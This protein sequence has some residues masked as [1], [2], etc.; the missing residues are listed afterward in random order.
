MEAI[1]KIII[2]TIPVPDRLIWILDPKGKFSIKLVF[3]VSQDP[4]EQSQPNI[5]WKPFWK[6][7][8]HERLK[9]LVWRIANDIL[10]TNLNFCMRVGFG[11]PICP[12]CHSE[13]ESAL[14]LFF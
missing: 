6:L 1:K 7:Q 10:P 14:H 3:F 8:L 11:N 2:S 5:Q 9:M 4:V 13:E 12:L